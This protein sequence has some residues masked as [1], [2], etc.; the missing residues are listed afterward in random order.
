MGISRKSEYRWSIGLR[1]SGWSIRALGYS[2][3][4]KLQSIREDI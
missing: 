1:T 3:R 2:A 4:E